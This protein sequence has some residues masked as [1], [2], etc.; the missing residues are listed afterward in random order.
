MQSAVR[1][2]GRRLVPRSLTAEP[3]KSRRPSVLIVDDDDAVRAFAAHALRGGGY[4]VRAVA[5][6]HTALKIVRRRGLL[7]LMMPLMSG[8]DIALRLRRDHPDVKILYFTG[9][10]DALFDKRETLWEHEAF[11]DKPV[12]IAGLQQAVSLL[13]FGHTRG[14][15]SQS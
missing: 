8:V 1:S 11:V 3:A 2:I 12:T 9:F 14:L 13:L 7:Y 4:A 5:D 15:S 10:S 6:G